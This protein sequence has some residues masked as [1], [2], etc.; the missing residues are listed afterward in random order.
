[1]RPLTGF[2]PLC[3]WVRWGVTVFHW[4]YV[5]PGQSNMFLYIFS[6]F[7]PWF[8]PTPSASSRVSKTSAIQFP[9]FIASVG[10]ASTFHTD[11]CHVA[12]M[13]FKGWLTVPV[14]MIT[15]HSAVTWLRIFI[16]KGFKRALSPLYLF[17]TFHLLPYLK[18]TGEHIWRAQFFI[19]TCP[20]SFP[21]CNPLYSHTSLLNPSSWL[22]WAKP[23]FLKVSEETLAKYLWKNR[24]IFSDRSLAFIHQDDYKVWGR[25]PSF[26]CCA[27]QTSKLFKFSSHLL[28]L[29]QFKKKSCTE[30]AFSWVCSSWDF[31]ELSSEN[32]APR[33][34]CPGSSKL[35]IFPCIRL[36]FLVY[37]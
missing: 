12:D 24:N 37:S 31:W 36:A 3:M 20:V 22:H 6:D 5:D 32:P 28:F 29:W 9:Q 33:S 23:V 18:N 34:F 26:S 25:P 7:W 4:E 19:C 1:M 35:N 16:F 21:R 27:A 17:S 10:T 8:P 11:E 30:L 15:D 14:I 13:P 2:R